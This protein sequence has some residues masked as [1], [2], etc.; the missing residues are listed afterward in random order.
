MKTNGE[1]IRPGRV[2][3]RLSIVGASRSIANGTV[4][5]RVWPMRCMSLAASSECP[6]NSKKLSRIP[7]GFLP[8]TSSQI[9]TNCDSN[10]SVAG[11]IASE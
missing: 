5:F 11:A 3:A 10:G 7:I 8:S 9:L 1:T 6:P 2:E 4:L